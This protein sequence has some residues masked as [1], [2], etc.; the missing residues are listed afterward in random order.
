MM[1][2]PIGRLQG[3]SL[4]CGIWNYVWGVTM[5]EMLLLCILQWPILVSF[6]MVW[7]E[8]LVILCFLIMAAVMRER[9]LIGFCLLWALWASTEATLVTTYLFGTRIAGSWPQATGSSWPSVN[10]P[11]PTRGAVDVRM[12]IHFFVVLKGLVMAT[13]AGA[14]CFYASMGATHRPRVNA[15][16]GMRGGG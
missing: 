14:V 13:V 12:L 8:S 16:I 1:D 3:A 4:F 10:N 11:P 15:R 5:N 6:S 2:S 7:I 9:F